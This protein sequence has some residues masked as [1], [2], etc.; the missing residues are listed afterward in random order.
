VQLGLHQL[1]RRPDP[2]PQV[3]RWF[4]RYTPHKAPLLAKEAS[5]LHVPA[6]TRG[7]CTGPVTRLWRA[8]ELRSETAGRLGGR[9]HVAIMAVLF[10]ALELP[11]SGTHRRRALNISPAWTQQ[12]RAERP[13][14][15]KQTRGRQPSYPGG[16][17]THQGYPIR[18][19]CQGRDT[20][21]QQPNQTI[22]ESVLA[23]GRE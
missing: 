18:V 9:H 11:C 2:G 16:L 14:Q 7:V 10:L 1:K 15:G 23:H 20:G 12:D 8:G 17:G 6:S 4:R 22:P 21:I 13:D 19:T 5:P 3:A